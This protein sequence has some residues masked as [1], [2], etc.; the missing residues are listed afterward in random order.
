M[1]VVAAAEELEHL[2]YNRTGKNKTSNANNEKGWKVNGMWIALPEVGS[3][4]FGLTSTL[5][6]MI[7]LYMRANS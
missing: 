1:V 5:C 6:L 3:I 4:F 7:A 2:I